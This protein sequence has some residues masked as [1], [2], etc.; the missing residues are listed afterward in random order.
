MS[1]NLSENVHQKCLQALQAGG[2]VCLLPH[3]IDPAW[4]GHALRL[5]GFP[6]TVCFTSL[7]PDPEPRRQVVITSCYDFDPSA[8]LEDADVRTMSYVTDPRS[9]CWVELVYQKRECTWEGRKLRDGMV[10][11]TAAG[12]DLR[13]LIIQLTMRGVEADEP[14]EVLRTLKNTGIERIYVFTEESQL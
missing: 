8:Y 10:L 1:T 12:P 5:A 7:S 13:Q 14:A 9:N 3:V 4:G 6:I 2:F 11:V